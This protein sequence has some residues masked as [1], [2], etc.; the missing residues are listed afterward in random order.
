ML[1]ELS[2]RTGISADNLRDYVA[3]HKPPQQYASDTHATPTPP[4]YNEPEA[5]EIYGGVDYQPYPDSVAART[6]KNAPV[7]GKISHSP[8]NQPPRDGRVCRGCRASSRLSR[9]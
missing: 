2:R 7:T 4:V 1:E 3:T 5:A 6:K 8:V 9:P